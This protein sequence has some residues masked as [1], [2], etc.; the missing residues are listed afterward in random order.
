M[1]LAIGKGQYHEN[2]D[3]LNDNQADG[4]QNYRLNSIPFYTDTE[5]QQAIYFLY[6]NG[7]D[8]NIAKDSCILAATNEKGYMWNKLIQ[9]MHESKSYSLFKI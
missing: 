5:R 8:S 2:A 3:I 4:I 9:D 6:P 1:I 7:F